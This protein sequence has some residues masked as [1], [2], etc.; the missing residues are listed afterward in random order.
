MKNHRRLLRIEFHEIREPVHPNYR[1]SSN[2]ARRLLPVYQ[3]HSS[4][5]HRADTLRCRICGVK[6]L[7]LCT[8]AFGK[9]KGAEF[10]CFLIPLCVQLAIQFIEGFLK[11]RC[12]VAGLINLQYHFS[13]LV[14]DSNAPRAMSDAPNTPSNS[15]NF[16]ERMS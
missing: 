8:A 11:L 2:E 5:P 3:M 9:Q 14:P 15:S 7:F 10:S 4:I 1:P 12:G 6:R 16:F 13:K